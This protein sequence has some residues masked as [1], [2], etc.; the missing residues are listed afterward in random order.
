MSNSEYKI[1]SNFIIC[2]SDKKEVKVMLS[3]QEGCTLEVLMKYKNQ[4]LTTGFITEEAAKIYKSKTGKAYKE[5]TGRHVRKLRERGLIKT[6]NKGNFIFDG[7]FSFSRVSPFSEKLK[8]EILKRDKYICQM[9]GVKS[10]NGAN[11]TVDHIIPQDRFGKAT[12]DNGM[13]LCTKC[14]NLKSNYGVYDFGKRMFK[15]YYQI[16]KKK[17][18]NKMMN[19][20]KEI[21]SVFEKYQKK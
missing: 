9:C 6:P 11:L 17:N 14:E 15:K 21:L 12:L 13:C 19:F 10:Q 20:F 5:L 16:S 1:H 18:D 4:I 8:K 7:D 3:S 2:K